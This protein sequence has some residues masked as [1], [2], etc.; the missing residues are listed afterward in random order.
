MARRLAFLPLSAI[1]E[2]RN[3]VNVSATDIKDMLY[4]GVAK[5]PANMWPMYGRE[6][7]LD[8]TKYVT[9]SEIGYCERKVWFDKEELKASAYSPLEGTTQKASGWGVLERGHNIEE[10]FVDTITRGLNGARLIMTGAYQRSFASRKQSGTPDGIFL[11][12]ERRCKTLEVKSIDPRTN[13]TRLPKYEHIRQITQNC[14]LVEQA[15]D[16]DCDGAILVYVD[17]S[18]YE[19]IYPHEIPFD[20]ELAASLEERAERI[21]S[22][23]NAKDLEPEG[24]HLGHCG[25]CRHTAACNALLKPVRKPVKEGTIDDIRSA[26]A[27]LFSRQLP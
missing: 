10:W 2:T 16:M 24:V 19:L 5:K 21:M 7:S 27:K 11:L 6:D 3:D 8:R 13:V 23:T 4:R 26:A 25:Y 14:D 12:P 9:A 18:N 17:A 1:S 15:L 22:A 20:H